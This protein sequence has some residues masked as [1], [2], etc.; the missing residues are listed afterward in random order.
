[1][2]YTQD[3]FDHFNKK[4]MS[5]ICF[6][7]KEVVLWNSMF[8]PLFV[9]L[10]GGENTANIMRYEIGPHFI[11]FTTLIIRCFILNLRDNQETE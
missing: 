5:F 2:S 10:H 6:I 3:D 8:S 4:L 9:I 1:M 7:P 11:S